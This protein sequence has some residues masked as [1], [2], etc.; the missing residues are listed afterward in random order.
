MIIST[1][2]LNLRSSLSNTTFYIL[3]LFSVKRCNIR[4]R[5]PR[6]ISGAALEVRKQVDGMDEM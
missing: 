1:F 5:M 3:S 2:S 4:G 6:P